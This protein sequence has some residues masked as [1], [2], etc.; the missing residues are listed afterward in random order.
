[1][2]KS[3]PLPQRSPRFPPR[4]KRS[5]FSINK[6]VRSAYNKGVEEITVSDAR[7]HGAFVTYL[8]NAVMGEIMRTGGSGEL[9][10]T[11]TRTA[12][13]FCLA[14]RETLARISDKLCEIVGVG[15]K[16]AFLQAHLRS[17]LPARERRLL[18]AALIAADY[19]GDLRFIRDRL[20]LGREICVDGVYAFRLGML[21]EKWAHI[22]EYI[23]VAFCEADLRQ[24]CEFLVGESRHKIYVKGNAVYGENFAPLRK[25]RLTG[26]EDAETEIMLADAGYVYCLGE[27][28]D[29]LGKFLQKYYADRAIFS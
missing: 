24:F 1:M 15:Y 20:V 5:A 8:Y 14:K 10:F 22:L 21:R 16:Y 17:C 29:S 25:S 7:E 6:S 18:C 11:D 26:S 19:E 2:K 23:P 12:A 27:V 4:G 3:A 28:E 9:L 13:R